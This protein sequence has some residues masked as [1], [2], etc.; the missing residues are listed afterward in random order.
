M[1]IV[2][3]DIAKN[4][5]E[6]SIISSSGELIG[7]SFKF[8]NNREGFQVLLSKLEK[9]SSDFSSFEFGMEATGH[10]WF[11]LYCKLLEYNCTVHVVNPI[12][13]DALRELYI[14][15][16]KN[17]SKDSF[18]IADL[19]RFGRYSETSLPE[20]D[21]VNLKELTRQRY[22][23]IDSIS[24]IKRK[25]ICL[26]D[27]IFPEYGTLFS[28]IFGATSMELLQNYTAPETIASLDTSALA[29]FLSKASRGKWGLKKATEIQECAKNTFGAFMFSD[30]SVFFIKQFL[31][32][33]KL[34]E[35]QLSELDQYI[36][37]LYSKYDSLLTTINGIGPITAASI[38][39]EIGD[40][41]RFDDPSK[42]AAFAGVDPSI[43]QS[44]EF[45][46]TQNKMSKRGSPYLRR[47][48][49]LAAFSAVQFNPA[50]KMIYDKKRAQGKAHTVA[51]T[52]VMRKLVNIIYVILKTQKPYKIIM[53]SD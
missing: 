2:G 27:K 51:L 49:Y 52:V 39:A 31:E 47:S 25:I 32:Q 48:L 24:D 45:S 5:H 13:S 17:D 26:L 38:F 40:I 41:N 20:T 43:K 35:N 33:I 30:S 21:I 46:G 50:M 7:R 22:Y 4:T 36:F 15:K 28:D 16:T 6:A 14:R 18:I 11:N 23:L 42:L 8:K 9:I 10:Y 19:I 44:G 3:I 29:D 37:E 12:Q 34:M 1:Y 53:P